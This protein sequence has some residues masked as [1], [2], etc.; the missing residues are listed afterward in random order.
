LD[1]DQIF[2]LALVV[3]QSLFYTLPVCFSG[4]WGV[5]SPRSS[6]K[7][8]RDLFTLPTDRYFIESLWCRISLSPEDVEK[9]EK[10][11]ISSKGDFYGILSVV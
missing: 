6:R 3:P 4:I 8:Y 10:N 2:S 11:G 5:D 9:E 1:Y 7:I